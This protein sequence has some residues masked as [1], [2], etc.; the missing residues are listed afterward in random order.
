MINK[1]FVEKDAPSSLIFSVLIFIGLL[2]S[3]AMGPWLASFL[4]I[5]GD[6]RAAVY[7]GDSASGIKFTLFW[8]ALLIGV[9]FQDRLFYKD[10]IN[11]YVVIILSIVTFNVFTGGYS[12]RLLAVSLPM[13]FSSLLSF[14]GVFKWLGLLLYLAYVSLQWIYWLHISV[15]S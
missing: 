5:L 4:S 9:F 6:R 14:N 2:F 10:K 13:I 11:A 15:I 1:M 12:S 3:I 7:S 8:S